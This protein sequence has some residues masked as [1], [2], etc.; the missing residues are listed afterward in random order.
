MTTYKDNEWKFVNKKK[1]R[2]SS[3]PNQRSRERVSASCYLANFPNDIYEKG[4][5]KL[6]ESYGR[7]VDVYVARKLYIKVWM[8]ICFCA[9]FEHARRQ[10][11]S[12]STIWVGY[13]HLF[14]SIAGF[15]R[16]NRSTNSNQGQ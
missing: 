10:C 15:T 12:L 5:W 9:V 4:I 13:Y 14:V 1:I 6:F 11:R 7:I 3:N 16:N 8:E 2:E